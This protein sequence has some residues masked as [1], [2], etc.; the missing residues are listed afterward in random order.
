MKVLHDMDGR[1]DFANNAVRAD[2]RCERMEKC[3]DSKKQ[4]RVLE[5]FFRA[6]RGE[7]VF[8][9]TLANEYDVSTKSIS[10]SISDIK[11][12]LADHRDLVGNT[13]LCYSHKDKC[14][15]LFMDE[16]LTNKELF[17]LVEV[18]I[19]ARAFSRPFLQF[20]R[21]IP[22]HGGGCRLFILL[23]TKNVF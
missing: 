16:F 4:D 7:D 19:G 9:S 1:I 23:K 21:M 10:R 2:L 12:F 17:A 22:Y 13:E 15:R 11:A 6:L 3:M 14:Y 8:V 18:I 5:I 20:A